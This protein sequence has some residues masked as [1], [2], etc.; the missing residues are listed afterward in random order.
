M[1]WARSSCSSG[2]SFDRGKYLFALTIE[3]FS[4]DQGVMGG[5]LTLKVSCDCGKSV[6]A[7]IDPPGSAVVLHNLPPTRHGHNKGR[8]KLVQCYNPGYSHRYL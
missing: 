5:L 8:R 4:Y 7:L 3:S 1:I 2:K 6:G